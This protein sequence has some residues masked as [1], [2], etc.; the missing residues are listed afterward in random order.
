[1]YTTN[2]QIYTAANNLTNNIGGFFSEI[3]QL[4]FALLNTLIECAMYAFNCII[5]NPILLIVFLLC[6]R[7]YVRRKYYVRK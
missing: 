1:M 3:V 4:I 6:F 7:Y 5:S 2:E